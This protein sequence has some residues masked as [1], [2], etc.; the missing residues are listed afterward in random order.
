[1]RNVFIP[2]TAAFLAVS[3]IAGGQQGIPTPE[4]VIG[5]PVGA[6]LKLIDYDQSMRVL[7]ATR[8]VEQSREARRRRKDVVRHAWTLVLISS[9]ENL[10]KLDRYADRAAARAPAGADRRRGARRWRTRAGRSST[11]TAACTRP[12][13]PARSTRCSSPTTSCRAPT[14]ADTKAMLDNVVLML[15]PTINPDGQQI[16][17][18]WYRK[19]VGTPYELSPLRELYQEYVGHDNNRDAYMLNMIES[20]V[21][22]HTWRQWEPQIIYVHHQSAP[23]P[24]RIWL[25]PFS[26]PVGI[27]ASRR[28]CRAR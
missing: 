21:V 22:E 23:F 13:S 3:S 2:L 4:S 27:H 18:K 15:W 24:T 20:R 26:E 10:A 12:R 5:Q 1:M 16:V 14:R 11:S 17:A 28:S 9:P 8:G 19:N 25:P 6:D 7:H